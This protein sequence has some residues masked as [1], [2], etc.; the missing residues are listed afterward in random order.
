MTFSQAY[1]NIQQHA[2]LLCFP[3]AVAC[4]SSHHPCL[5]RGSLLSTAQQ[6]AQ[7]PQSLLVSLFLLRQLPLCFAESVVGVIFQCFVGDFHLTQ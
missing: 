5:H 3:R 6:V 7:I 2:R 1:Q 4:R